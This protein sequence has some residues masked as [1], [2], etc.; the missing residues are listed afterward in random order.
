MARIVPIFF[1]INMIYSKILCTLTNFPLFILLPILLGRTQ[2]PCPNDLLG[3]LNVLRGF[4]LP[5]QLNTLAW[6]KLSVD[7]VN[8]VCCFEWVNW[9]LLENQQV[10]K[11][12]ES[13]QKPIIIPFML[14]SVYGNFSYLHKKIRWGGCLL[15]IA[16]LEALV[17]MKIVSVGMQRCPSL[18][19]SGDWWY[20]E[21]IQ[22]WCLISGQSC[23][24][25]YRIFCECRSGHAEELPTYG[26]FQYSSVGY[27]CSPHC[28]LFPLAIR[29]DQETKC[30][31]TGEV[32]RQWR[33]GA[34]ERIRGLVKAAW[35][36]SFQPSSAEKLLWNSLCLVKGRSL[37]MW[38]L[39]EITLIGSRITKTLTTCCH[40]R[41]SGFVCC[42]ECFFSLKTGV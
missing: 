21:V 11:F 17:H 19:K 23:C 30:R 24:N 14:P 7:L 2:S 3:Q 29:P 12:Q 27:F 39:K 34:K 5:L 36:D 13:L 16:A 6:L 40:E 8:P 38:P 10:G 28:S 31:A 4:F 33:W 32:G 42:T 22:I 41:R 26:P 35:L 1:Q 37:F 15:G 20:S 9:L 25:F 18:I